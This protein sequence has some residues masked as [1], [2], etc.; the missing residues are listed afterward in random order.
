M[1]HSQIFRTFNIWQKNKPLLPYRVY[2][3]TEVENTS[4]MPSIPIVTNRALEDILQMPLHLS[5]TAKLREKT[6][7]YVKPCAPIWLKFANISLGGSYSSIK[8]H[9]EPYASSRVILES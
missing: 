2:A 8:L 9:Y 3:Q 6:S 7:T 5:K 1:R 4:P